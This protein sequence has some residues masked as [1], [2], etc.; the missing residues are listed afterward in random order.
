MN[1]KKIMALVLSGA[2]VASLALTGCNKSETEKK[3][4]TYTVGICQLVQHPALDDATK[5]FKD[6]L[7]E[8]LGDKVKFDEQNAS[9]D[10]NICTTIVNQFVGAD[11]DLIMANATPA[12]QAAVSATEDIPIIAT[13]ITDYATALDI[14]DWTGKTGINVAGTADLAPLDKQANIFKE[15]LPEAKTVGIIYCSSEPNSKYQSN[16]ITG[17][18]KDMGLTV[19]EYTFADSN[20]IAAVVTKACEDC[21]ALYVPT[22]NQAASNTEIIDGIAADAKKPIVAGEEG[23][24]K[25]CGIATLSI[26]YYSIGYNAGLQAYDVL[27]NGKNPA[28]IEIEYATDL[29]YE[30]FASRCEA[31]GITV[32]DTYKAIEEAAE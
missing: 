9:N 20:D 12:L 26:S 18:L 2:M 14:S 30:Y 5:G 10:S 3:D 1:F 19:T 29:T 25:G 21:D 11:V 15:L 4:D 28:D 16:V 17:Y 7:T 27:V 24:C 32:P 31:L 13:S 8:K 22:D 6:A 23:I